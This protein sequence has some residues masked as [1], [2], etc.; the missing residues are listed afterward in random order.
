MALTNMK[1]SADDAK[2]EEVAV[3]QVSPDGGPRYPYGLSLCLDKESMGKL[4]MTDLPEIGGKMLLTAL[5]E[6]TSVSQYQTQ[7]SQ[8]KSVH[9]QITDMELQRPSGDA[10]RKLYGGE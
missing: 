10:A 2:V 4:G 1:L 6:V 8:D 9:L 5:V 7:E 3:P